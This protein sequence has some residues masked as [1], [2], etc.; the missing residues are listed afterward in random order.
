MFLI[1]ISLNIGKYNRLKQKNT[2][3]YTKEC[4]KNHNNEYIVE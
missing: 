1:I 3:N 4:I 2:K